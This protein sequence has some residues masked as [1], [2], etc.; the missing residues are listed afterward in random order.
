MKFKICVINKFQNRGERGIFN[1]KETK[2]LVKNP[3]PVDKCRLTAA[4]GYWMQRDHI[5]Q[6]N[7][8]TVISVQFLSVWLLLWQ[9][10]TFITQTFINVPVNNCCFEDSRR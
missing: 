6:Y 4:L 10:F 1:G 8:R 5:I 3:D 9:T 7:V 2:Q